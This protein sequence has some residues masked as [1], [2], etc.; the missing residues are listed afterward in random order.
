MAAYVPSASCSI[1][2]RSDDLRRL[3]S[4]NVVSREIKLCH[5]A[6]ILGIV[7]ECVCVCV[8]VCACVGFFPHASIRRS[9]SSSSR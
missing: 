2:L 4:V 6:R 9:I 3:R 1:H 5:K 8:Y 7:R